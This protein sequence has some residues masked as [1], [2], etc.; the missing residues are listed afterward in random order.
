ML[1][2]AVSTPLVSRLGDG[3]NR[4]TVLIVALGVCATGSVLSSLHSGLA[5]FL[6]GRA[7][8][9]A[10]TGLV[11]VGMSIIRDHLPSERR[12]RAVGILSVSAAA[13]VGIGYPVTGVIADS[14]GFHGC[15]WIAAAVAAAAMILIV[16]VVPDAAHRP[17]VSLNLVGSALLVFG[18]GLVLLALSQLGRGDGRRPGTWAA[19]LRA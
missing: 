4:R 17:S 15:Y 9:G 10:A 19:L 16:L 8:Q 14:I 13:G 1:V 5:L 2:G 12:R 3:R 6:I 7:L 11:P 18:L